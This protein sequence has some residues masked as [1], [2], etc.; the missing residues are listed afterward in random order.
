MMRASRRGSAAGRRADLRPDC[1][2]VFP[3]HAGVFPRYGFAGP[4]HAVFLARGVLRV[5]AALALVYSLTCPGIGYF[6]RKSPGIPDCRTG[7]GNLSR[8]SMVAG[9]RGSLAVYSA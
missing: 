8:Q 4:A 7:P 9:V 1:R 6:A 2:P 3:A 5:A